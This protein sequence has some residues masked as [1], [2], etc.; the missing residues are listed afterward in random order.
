M[1]KLMTILFIISFFGNACFL[2]QKDNKIYTIVEEN[3]E[4]PGGQAAL[5]KYLSQNLKYP[6]NDSM[7]LCG[8]MMLQFV[9]EK[10]GRAIFDSCKFRNCPLQ[11]NEMKSV[12]NNMPRWKA[13]RQNG[14]TVRVALSLPIHIRLE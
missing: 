14:K 3:P 8:R 9:V 4:Y 1:I 2:G 11:C 5:F 10:N 7:D 6:K 13:G 12:I